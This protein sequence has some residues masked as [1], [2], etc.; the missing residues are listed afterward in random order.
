MNDETLCD[1][2]VCQ[3]NRRHG[4]EHVEDMTDEAA[5]KLIEHAADVA[6]WFGGETGIDMNDAK[7]AGLLICAG[8]AMLEREEDCNAMTAMSIAQYYLGRAT[9]R[10][11]RNRRRAS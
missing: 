2:A 7:A 5:A 1:C 9:T 10:A 3:S 8:M 11:E 4:P 6:K